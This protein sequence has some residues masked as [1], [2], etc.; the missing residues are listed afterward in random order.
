MNKKEFKK[1]WESDD[2]GGGITFDDVANCAREW[3]LYDRPK[4][5]SI[6][7]VLYSVLVA[8]KVNDAEDYRC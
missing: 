8:A 3:G 2:N 5:H 6:D 7:S 4:I 1:L